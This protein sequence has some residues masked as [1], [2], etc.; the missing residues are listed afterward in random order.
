MSFSVV[1][2]GAVML[3]TVSSQNGKK[4]AHPARKHTDAKM[5]F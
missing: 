5:R 4:P 2:L 1:I 3:Q